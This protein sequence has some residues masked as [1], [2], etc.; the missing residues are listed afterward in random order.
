MRFVMLPNEGRPMPRL[1]PLKT[2]GI[3]MLLL[4]ISAVVML[5]MPQA[6]GQVILP[7][8]WSPSTGT[9]VSAE[10]S[11]G[12]FLG[13]HLEFVA[14][15]PRLNT[16]GW[17]L[18]E[19]PVVW[20]NGDAVI[21]QV[22]SR[23]W[24]QASF[25]NYSLVR[26]ADDGITTAPALKSPNPILVHDHEDR[27]YTFAESNT[28]G[29]VVLL[30][31][32]TE[33]LDPLRELVVEFPMRSRSPHPGWTMMRHSAILPDGR[34]AFLLGVD[35]TA[36]LQTYS[37]ANP[38]QTAFKLYLVQVDPDAWSDATVIDLNTSTLRGHP[39]FNANEEYRTQ[40]EGHIKQ[41][42]VEVQQ[43]SNSY[44]H[45]VLEIDF[46]QGT[47]SEAIPH[48]QANVGLQRAYVQRQS[49]V[50]Y[51]DIDYTRTNV[52]INEPALALGIEQSVSGLT[53]GYTPTQMASSHW[54]NQKHAPPTLLDYFR[55][56]QYRTL[57]WLQQKNVGISPMYI[58]RNT[59]EMRFGDV[60]MASGN[61]QKNTVLR[62]DLRDTWAQM[63]GQYVDLQ[64]NP[65]DPN[66]A[67]VVQMIATGKPN[68][69]LP[70]RYLRLGVL[71]NASTEV[72][73]R[74]YFEVTDLT[75][76]GRGPKGQYN[77][78]DMHVIPLDDEGNALIL[79]PERDWT[80]H[81]KAVP[82]HN[83]AVGHPHPERLHWT[84]VDLSPYFDRA[85]PRAPDSLQPLGSVE[86]KDDLVEELER[87]LNE[88][89]VLEPTLD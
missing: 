51:G 37:T 66:S 84:S 6:R 3:V 73:W 18:G 72:D 35:P 8:N 9:E 22:A 42:T 78:F 31:I 67:L 36:G 46:H 26:Y 47:V 21:C 5:F 60:L 17:N 4:V 75:T 30:E 65:F 33:T 55:V 58:W 38:W 89:E 81:F 23:N 25:T 32:D 61:S 1:T 10:W 68:A 40:I 85:S 77:T 79:L 86:D 82:N 11:T 80:H 70:R 13:D 83:S 49:L 45:E 76:Q 28:A 87:L 74:C 16:Y 27:V 52:F 64:P 24:Q 63:Y 34:M 7:R 69:A 59:N 15:Q 53:Q 48:N 50:P 2:F 19:P 41:I 43:A 56:L 62:G 20:T 44:R 57:T 14:Y 54:A 29:E 12:P 71:H 88:P 39:S